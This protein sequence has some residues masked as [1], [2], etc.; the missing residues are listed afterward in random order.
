MP[1]NAA[2]TWYMSAETSVGPSGNWKTSPVHKFVSGC[3]QITK[4]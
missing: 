2:G 4:G 3:F 1:Q